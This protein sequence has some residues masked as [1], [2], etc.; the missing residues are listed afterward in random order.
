MTP[1][2]PLAAI[3]V[4]V[5]LA[6]AAPPP[7]DGGAYSPSS[8]F[9]VDPRRRLQGS[10]PCFA[11]GVGNFATCCPGANAT[12]PY[13]TDGVCTLLSCLEIDDL[14]LRDDCSCY[15]IVVACD[16]VSIFAAFVDQI[17]GMCT[18]VV[19][20]CAYGGGEGGGSGAS[21]RND[22]DSSAA[23]AS[24]PPTIDNA[25]WNECMYR[26]EDMGNYTIPDFSALIPGESSAI[27]LGP[28][29]NVDVGSSAISPDIVPPPPEE[30]TAVDAVEGEEEEEEPPEIETSSTVD[31]TAAAD[32]I[33]A[34]AT[35]C[36]NPEWFAAVALI[37]ALS[38]MVVPGLLV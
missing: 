9:D 17:P 27:D 11:S 34:A 2:A 20:C 21:A 26:A 6:I 30:T 12:G 29:M 13:P 31:A 37:L 24:L 5:S 32:P 35:G 19:A 14:S 36:A 15:D 25:S 28:Q 4:V 33:P 8:M 23:A 38:S 3:A 1:S 22:S 16:Q 10:V 18:S 7:P